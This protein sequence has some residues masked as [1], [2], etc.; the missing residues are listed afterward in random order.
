MEASIASALEVITEAAA[1][2][3]DELMMKYLEGEALTQEELLMGFSAGM[4]QRVKSPLWYPCSAVTTVGVT[5]LLDV[6]ADFLPS[7]ARRV[8]EGKD[9]KSDRRCY[10]QVRQQRT[11]LSVYL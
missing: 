2:A 4:G 9:P 6:I 3:D 5:K 7:P 8:Y 10:P 1:G 11:V